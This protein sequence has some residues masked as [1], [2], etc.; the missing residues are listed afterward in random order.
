MSE[1]RDQAGEGKSETNDSISQVRGMIG[2]FDG[3]TKKQ[4]V[5]PQARPR[6]RG[7]R[8]SRTELSRIGCMNVLVNLWTNLTKL[9]RIHPLILLYSP[10]RLY[11]ID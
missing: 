5:K 3:P 8:V 4:E 9:L 10:G 2:E 7:E 6:V 1:A 11:I